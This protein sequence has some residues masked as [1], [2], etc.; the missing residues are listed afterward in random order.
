[1]AGVPAAVLVAMVSPWATMLAVAVSKPERA[2]CQLRLSTM[3]PEYIGNRGTSG[4]PVS[5]EKDGSAQFPERNS[6]V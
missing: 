5:T 2:I 6:W 1:M 4:M 3:Q